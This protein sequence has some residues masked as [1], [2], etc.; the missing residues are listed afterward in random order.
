M[1]K[2]RREGVTA[3]FQARMFETAELICASGHQGNAG[4]PDRRR[5]QAATANA[6]HE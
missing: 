1:S 5:S 3:F 4:D 6:L 2:Q